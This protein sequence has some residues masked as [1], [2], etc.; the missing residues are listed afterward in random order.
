MKILLSSIFLI[1]LCQNSLADTLTVKLDGT[2]DYNNIQDAIGWS[3]S[4]DV[5]LVYPGI[6]YENIDCY[7][8][9]SLTIASLYLLN[10]IDS[11]I[12]NT[13]INGNLNGTCIAA[14]RGEENLRIIGFTITNGSGNTYI[15]YFISDGGG[16]LL[17][18]VSAS[19]EN[20]IIENNF[21]L[22]G[23]GLL[24]HD[25]YVFL[26]GTKIRYNQAYG[27][28]G[29]ITNAGYEL[30]FDTT[31]LCDLYLNY[32]QR[33]TDYSQYYLVSRPVFHLDTATV[34][35]PDDYYFSCWD[36]NGFDSCNFNFSIENAKIQDFNSDLYVNPSGSDLNSG[37][38]PEDPLKTLSFA[39]LK[40]K[41][42][43]STRNTI[44][45]ANGTYSPSN[46]NRFPIGLKSNIDIVGQNREHTIIDLDSLI[47][48]GFGRAG[49]KSVALKN[50]SIQN[51]RGDSLTT[52]S[53]ILY[54][55]YCLN[56]I[57]EDLKFENCSAKEI[58]SVLTSEG[59]DSLIFRNTIFEN[60][61]VAN[62]ASV[63]G[64][65]FKLFI[66]D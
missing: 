47:T 41:S 24:S 29:G 18:G 50:F 45:L 30:I 26:S 38:T 65:Y 33:G 48:F 57:L 60:N 5:I 62:V 52:V 21:A 12:N 4:G 8:R 53:T 11:I 23:A 46:G 28:G 35:D 6:Y 49:L 54:L 22:S 13:I 39:L 20:C 64:N 63:Y 43:S 25:S 16:I 32:S 51:G 10:P 14:F 58:S 34:I 61:H 9:D 15:S 3:S 27:L 1:I 56:V 31:N 55:R 44:H 37:L 40:I 36:D 66:A 17:D 42:D 2:G 19:I 59:C 7:G